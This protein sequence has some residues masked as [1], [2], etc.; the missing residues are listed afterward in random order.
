[1]TSAVFA[2]YL[3]SAGLIVGGVFTIFGRDP[4]RSLLWLVMAVLSASGLFVLLGAAYVAMLLVL[5]YVGAVALIFLVVVRMLNVDFAGL[6]A[7]PGRYAPFAVLIGVV[8]LMQLALSV[9]V[10]ATAEP[11][12]GAVAGAQ[13]TKAI[14]L[15]LF[16]LYALPF[17][18]AGL[19]L[20]VAMVGAVVLTLRDRDEGAR[21]GKLAQMYRNPDVLLDL[22]DIKSEN[23]K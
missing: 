18:L 22:S 17:Q 19:V 3:F 9:G 20:L 12:D 11:A 7:D 13:N 16:D 23:R 5:V 6:K 4:V 10:W 2:F 14:G 21:T 8:C 1:M 15:V